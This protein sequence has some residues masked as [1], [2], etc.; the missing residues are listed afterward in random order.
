[1]GPL[2][3]DAV[4]QLHKLFDWSETSRRGVLLFIDEADAFLASRSKTNMSENQVRPCRRP[5]AV[6]C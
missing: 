6:V 4:T 1:M 5:A 3:P 2:G